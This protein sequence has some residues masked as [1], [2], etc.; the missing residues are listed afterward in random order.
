MV[1]SEGLDRM[2]ALGPE[3]SETYKILGC[4]QE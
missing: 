1:K 2:N 4:E 3:T